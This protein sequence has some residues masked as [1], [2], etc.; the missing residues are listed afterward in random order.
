[1]CRSPVM[2]FDPGGYGRCAHQKCSV[3]SNPRF[4]AGGKGRPIP[5][6]MPLAKWNGS[7]VAGTLQLSS[8]QRMC[9]CVRLVCSFRDGAMIG[10][11]HG[12]RTLV[13]RQAANP[14]RLALAHVSAVLMVVAI[15]RSASFPPLF[16]LLLPDPQKGIVEWAQQQSSKPKVVTFPPAPP[17]KAAAPPAPAPAAAAASQPPAPQPTRPPGSAAAAA[18][19]P[20]Q[21]AATESA[22]APQPTCTEEELLVC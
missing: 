18:A 15:D 11:Y 9:V 4:F 6:C 3:K 21:A 8:P 13:R 12:E 2:S 22:A 19:P 10:Q 1:L 17:P 5:D 7:V 16:S 20:A 14:H